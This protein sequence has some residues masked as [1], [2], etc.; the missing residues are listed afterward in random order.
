MKEDLNLKQDVNQIA[1]NWFEDRKWDININLQPHPSVNVVEFYI[2]YHNNKAI[3]NKVFSFL[4]EQDLEILTTGK[5]IIDEDNAFAMI[6]EYSTKDIDDCRWESHVKYI[7][8]QHIIKGKEN[9]GITSI[10]KT[11][12]TDPYDENN[13]I[14][15][16]TGEGAYHI[17]SPYAFF[18]FF[19]QD[20]HRPCIKIGEAETVKKL[21]VK[22]KKVT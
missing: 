21:V 15:F 9:M 19:P 17:A 6:S 3:W 12:V 11:V 22:I 7:D 5:Y 20:V 2:Q 8:L 4:K 10:D 1:Q 16:Y 13:D 18:L 14:I